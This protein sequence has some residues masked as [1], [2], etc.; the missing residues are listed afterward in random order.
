MTAKGRTSNIFTHHPTVN[1]EYHGMKYIVVVTRLQPQSVTIEV[2]AD[3]E[4]EAEAI[5]LATCGDHVFE[6]SGDAEDEVVESCTFGE[7]ED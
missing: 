3:S 4:A 2:H 6:S 7:E 5:A 1:K